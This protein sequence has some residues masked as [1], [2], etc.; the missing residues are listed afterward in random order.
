MDG[1]TF[2]F[3]GRQ[4]TCRA[5]ADDSYDLVSEKKVVGNVSVENG[6]INKFT[7]QPSFISDY[8]TG[9]ELIKVIANVISGDN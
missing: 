1:V 2:E 8:Q 3:Q 4:L 7:F 6:I 5:Y 9:L